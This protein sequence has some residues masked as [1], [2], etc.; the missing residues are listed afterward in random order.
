[1]RNMK[2]IRSAIAG[3]VVG[4]GLAVAVTSGT[5]EA[6]PNPQESCAFNAVTVKTSQGAQPI[7]GTAVTINNGDQSRKV[8]VE[9]SADMGVDPGA[10]VRLSYSIDGKPPQ[11][12][13]YG[14]AN[15]A[16]HAEF[17]ET[18]HGLAVVPLGPG[19]HTI[20][21]YWRISSAGERFGFMDS[22]CVVAEGRTS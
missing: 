16:N 1:M 5:A 9:F 2:W 18:R 13:V 19:T 11:E 20:Q 17:W 22:R 21:P 6:I 4:A 10:E 12:D 8:V 7:P 15:I 3:T 14:P